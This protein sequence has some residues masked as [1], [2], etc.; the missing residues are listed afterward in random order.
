MNQ[1]DIHLLDLPNETLLIIMK[2]LDNIDVLYSFFGINNK[3]LDI[4]VEDDAFASILNFT[5]ISSIA[6]VKFDR[7]CSSILP[8]INQSIK[9]LI[10]KTTSMERILLIGNYSNL[11][12]LELF[13]FGQEIVYRRFTGEHITFS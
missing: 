10:L 8:R 2:K 3:R 4:L 9:K 5:R 13:N 6:D 7:F 1:S 11:T 12:S